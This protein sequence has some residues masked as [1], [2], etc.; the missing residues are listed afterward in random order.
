VAVTP[1]KT[2]ITTASTDAITEKAP[3]MAQYHAFGAPG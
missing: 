2:A 1:Q 3:L